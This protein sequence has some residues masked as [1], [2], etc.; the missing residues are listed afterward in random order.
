MVE[1]RDELRELFGR[2]RD[3]R[4]LRRQIE[5]GKGPEREVDERFSEMTKRVEVSQVTPAQLHGVSS[6]L[7]QLERALVGS[8]RVSF[9]RWR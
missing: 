1:G 6:R 8:E 3:A 9:T 7:F 2:E 4:K 5:G